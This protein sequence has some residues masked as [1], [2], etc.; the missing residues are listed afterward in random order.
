M[1]LP[2]NGVPANLLPIMELCKLV[3]SD[4]GPRKEYILC[5]KKC[6]AIESTQKCI[7]NTI[8]HH[9]NVERLVFDQTPST[10]DM[11]AELV[12]SVFPTNYPSIENGSQL[13]NLSPGNIYPEKTSTHEY[14]DLVYRVDRTKRGPNRINNQG[15][16]PTHK[17]PL[18]NE[19]ACARYYDCEIVKHFWTSMDVWNQMEIGSLKYQEKRVLKDIF[20]RNLDAF[21]RST[22]DTGSFKGFEYEMAKI[23]RA[24]INEKH[25]QAHTPLPHY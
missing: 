17:S 25:S 19:V 10:I 14:A 2:L 21:A 16:K 5:I 3:R 20:K 11:T 8:C 13:K 15:N 9:P 7:N 24:Q 23:R 6:L 22:D 12:P 18:E 1:K 4:V